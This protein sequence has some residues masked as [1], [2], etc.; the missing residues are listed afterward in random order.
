M[1]FNFS[2]EGKRHD[3]GMLR[4][5]HLLDDLELHAFS[6]APLAR[7]LCLYGDPA[8]PLRLH[9]Q[10]PFRNIVLTPQMEEF[11][12]SMS[13]IRISV[14]WLFGDI[15]NYFKFIDFKKNLKVGLSAVGKLYI[16]CALLRNALTCLYGNTTSEYFDL[17]PPTL[18]DYFA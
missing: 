2:S 1:K 13:P 18:Q 6:P 16:I 14:E 3:A 5:S 12:R 11:N 9:L 4:D 7:P 17:D 15:T 10:A 8:Y